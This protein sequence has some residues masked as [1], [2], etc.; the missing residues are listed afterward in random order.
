VVRGP[1][2]PD[3]LDVIR[4]ERE[5]FA[6]EGI[7]AAADQEANASRN[8]NGDRRRIQPAREV[9]ASAE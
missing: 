8:G 1:R 9:E 6:R 2:P 3:G 4:S 7:Q 5:R